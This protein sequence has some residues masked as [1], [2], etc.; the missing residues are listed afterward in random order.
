MMPWE[1]WGWHWGMMILMVLFWVGVIVGIVLLVTWI[2]QQPGR[3]IPAGGMPPQ[4]EPLTT[5]KRRYARGEISREEYE[6]MRQD[7]E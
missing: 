6:R 2:A 3:R 7:L 1:G 5:L 4:E